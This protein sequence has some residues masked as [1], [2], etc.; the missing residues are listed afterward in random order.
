MVSLVQQKTGDASHAITR[1]GDKS[2]APFRREDRE[3]SRAAG[4]QAPK[5]SV[6][7]EPFVKGVPGLCRRLRTRARTFQNCFE[8]LT[9]KAVT[10]EE[11]T[12]LQHLQ[13]D[14]LPASGLENGHHLRVVLDAIPIDEVHACRVKRQKVAPFR[15]AGIVPGVETAIAKTCDDTCE[16]QQERYPCRP[17]Q[18]GL[19]RHPSDRR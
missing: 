12:A 18:T 15:T 17:S 9:A 16:K 3:A 13:I 8:F 10:I 14:F 1:Q 7:Q 6:A 5:L 19:P 11:R 4:P 2:P